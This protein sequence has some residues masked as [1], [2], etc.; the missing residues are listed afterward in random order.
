VDEGNGTPEARP[1]RPFTGAALVACVAATLAFSVY[2]RTLLPGVDLGDTGGFQ[3]AVLW[4]ETSARQAYPLYYSLAR[5]FVLAVSPDNP[6]RGL[7]LFSAVCG[8]LA[9]GLLTYVAALLSGS[10]LA[11]ALAG[12]LLAFSHTF[13]TQ[14][15]IAEVYAL[16]IALVAGCLLALYAYQ[17]QP[18]RWR[19]ALFFAVYAVSFG[20]HLS[21]ILLL[22]PFT[23]FLFAVHPRPRDLLRLRT[24]GL[25]LGIAVTAALL[26]APN[27][28]F[29]LTNIDAPPR[30]GDRVA[31][32]WFDVTK[33]DW[34]GT[35]MAGVDRSELVERA[36][37]WLWDA[38]LQFGIAGLTI[39][40]LGML[41]LWVISRPWALLV[42]TA[43]A[44]NTVFAITYNVGDP[45]V[46]FLPGHVFTAVAM[47]ALFSQRHPIKGRPTSSEHTGSER[48]APLLGVPN[49]RIQLATIVLLAYAGW[50]AWDTWP[51]A[52]RHGDH[53]ADVLVGRVTAG[54]ADTNAVLLSDMDWQSENAL[55]YSARYERRQLAWRRASE[56][57][58]HLPFLVRDN[59]SIGRDIV[60]AGNAAERIAAAYGPLFPFVADSIAA[61]GMADRV[62]DVPRGTP[63]VLAL[64]EPTPNEHLDADDVDA[65]VVTLAGS[66]A[67]RRSRSRFQIWAGVAGEPGAAHHESNR[68]F[69]KTFSILGDPFSV[70]IESWLPFETFRRAGFGHVL[71]GREHVL[72]IERGVSLVWFERDGSPVVAYAA[73]LYAPRARLRVPASVPQQVAMVSG[74]ILEIALDVARGTPPTK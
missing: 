8:G 29:V 66:S 58:L 69:R 15:V 45:H 27:V 44:I 16:H 73:G 26:Y 47:A 48:R 22:V 1:G 43:Y 7:N 55:L 51:S 68:P 72:T 4:P 34:R 18:T 62:A 12:L 71:R 50:R 67:P 65:A 37:M 17:Q 23:V 14:S 31:I 5:P 54:V 30:W 11:G 57:L 9:I 40:I 6:A 2:A 19:L 20:N 49:R 52:N 13:W 70:R 41:R 21:M 24:V 35:M 56:V 36:A 46:F 10:A 64:L 74:A 39:A 32:F 33:A 28:L 25:A 53:R 3:A 63:Y 61:P 59:H 42:A 38:R 60:L